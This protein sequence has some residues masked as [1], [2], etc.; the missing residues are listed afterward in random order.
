MERRKRG[1]K[2]EEKMDYGKEKGRKK[3]RKKERIMGG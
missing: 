2:E 1:I 3:S